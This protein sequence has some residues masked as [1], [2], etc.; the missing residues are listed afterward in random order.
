MSRG[1]EIWFLK[2]GSIEGCGGNLWGWGCYWSGRFFTFFG[3]GECK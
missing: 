1:V 2:E 3:V